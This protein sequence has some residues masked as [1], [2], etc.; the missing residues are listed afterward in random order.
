MRV[1]II[2]LSPFAHNR[3][4]SAMTSVI[5]EYLYKNFSDIEVVFWAGFPEPANPC[6]TSLYYNQIKEK[7]KITTIKELIYPSRVS[8]LKQTMELI[9]IS[10]YKKLHLNTKHIIKEVLNSDFVLS[11][12]YG[13]LFSD[14]HDTLGIIGTITIMKNLVPLLFKKSVVFGPQTIGP[15]RKVNIKALAINI[16]NNRHVKCIMPRELM[17]LG[18]TCRYV[19]SKQKIVFC[20]DLAFLLKA[21]FAILRIIPKEVLKQGYIVVSLNPYQI[22][23]RIYNSV[24]QLLAK[25]L[26]QIIN[27][28]NKYILFLPHATSPSGFDSRNMALSIVKL[29]N[30]RVRNRVLVLL[31]DYT[32]EELKGIISKSE[33]VISTLTHPLIHGLSSGIGVLGVS[34][35]SPKMAYILRLFDMDKYMVRISDLINHPHKL[36]YKVLELLHPSLK[37]EIKEKTYKKNRELQKLIINRL[38]YA[39]DTI[40]DLGLEDEYF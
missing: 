18:F 3:G 19:K 26:C 32:A 21:D 31:K 40:L 38:K 4:V 35:K 9:R 25:L 16:L 37:K 10:F 22:S 23:H 30:K 34:S 14:A 8:L 28:T 15:F 20:P 5:L 17:S 24:V 33:L 1:L 7:T 39:F 11:F 2:G 27:V 12:N 6:P 36:V 13:D 29:M